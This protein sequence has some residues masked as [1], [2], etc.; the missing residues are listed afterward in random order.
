MG[1]PLHAR[2]V[3]GLAC[4]LSVHQTRGYIMET[5]DGASLLRLRASREQASSSGPQTASKQIIRRE[6]ELSLCAVFCIQE[7]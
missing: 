3:M 5:G 1:I 2:G 7:V 6:L 4:M